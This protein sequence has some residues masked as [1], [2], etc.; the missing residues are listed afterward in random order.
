MS[1]GRALADFGLH[2]F[3]VPL[4]SL[5]LMTNLWLSSFGLWTTLLFVSLT[6]VIPTRSSAAEIKIE[7]PHT[8]FTFPYQ[9]AQEAKPAILLDNLVTFEVNDG[10]AR[11][12][13]QRRLDLAVGE[14]SHTLKVIREKH[15]VMAIRF[16]VGPGAKQFVR[17]SHSPDEA[18]VPFEEDVAQQLQAEWAQYLGVDTEEFN[19]L[20]MPLMLVP[21]GEFT[22]GTSPEDI[23]EFTQNE[24]NP[25]WVKYCT[26]EGPQH[27]VVI[28]RPF[29]LSAFEV[30]REEFREF[31]KA[32]GYQTDA[33]RDGKGGYGWNPW[34]QSPEVTWDLIPGLKQ[35]EAGPVVNVSWNDA[36]AYC[37]WLSKVEQQTYRL[38]TEAEWEYACRAGSAGKWSFPND[39]L[40]LLST[41]S[42]FGY[43]DGASPHLVGHKLPNAFGLFDMH[44]NVYEW[45]N[46]WYS[47]DYYQ[48]SPTVDPVGPAQGEYRVMRGGSFGAIPKNLRNAHRNVLESTGRTPLVGFRVLREIEHAPQELRK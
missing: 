23:K 7:L 33:E 13:E 41:H 21:P 25:Y 27:R 12:P 19:S 22:M 2:L 4:E 15:E 44:G 48:Q 46:D 47:E 29:L 5:D 17:I 14:G 24:A 1:K 45:C 8:V 35:K 26:S 6:I 40:N 38:P 42:V 30:T 37:K 18:I 31:I 36:V 16:N 28:S 9:P 3:A 43:H 32:T 10:A 39:D 34:R 11:Q 20:D